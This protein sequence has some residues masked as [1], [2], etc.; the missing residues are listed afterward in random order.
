MRRRESDNS[1]V[2]ALN[3]ALVDELK[4]KGCIQTPS[5][6]AAFRAVLRHLFVPGS[7]LSIYLPVVS[8]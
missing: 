4:D 5:I 1:D 3:Q 6:E 2:I 7:I 8:W